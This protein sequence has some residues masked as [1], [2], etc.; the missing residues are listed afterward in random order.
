MTSL[1]A[2]VVIPVKA[3]SRSKGRLSG[4]LPEWQRM[5]LAHAMFLDLAD[6]VDAAGLAG[7]TVVTSDPEVA[8]LTVSRGGD[9]CLEQATGLNAAVEQGLYQTFGRASAQ[10]V[11]PID[12]PYLRPDE[13]VRAADVAHSGSGC[14]VRAVDG[15][16]NLVAFPTAARIAP[17]FGPDSF[18]LHIQEMQRAGLPVRALSASG[19]QLDLDTFDDLRALQAS[20]PANRVGQLVARLAVISGYQPLNG[21]S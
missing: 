19:L 17:R 2:W 14:A 21:A 7:W 18:R 5:Q 12:V 16:T 1:D 9:L 15:G 6:T 3:F 8:R 11:I 13:L 4:H 20:P 10:I